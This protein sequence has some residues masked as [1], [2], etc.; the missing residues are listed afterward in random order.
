MLDIAV[1]FDRFMQD[2]SVISRLRI[3]SETMLEP[4]FLSVLPHQIRSGGILQNRNPVADDTRD[5]MRAFFV[6]FA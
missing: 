1:I 5:F 3:Y 2:P 4:N 6:C